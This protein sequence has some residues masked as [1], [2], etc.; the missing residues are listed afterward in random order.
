MRISTIPSYFLLLPLALGLVLPALT[1]CGGS[2]EPSGGSGYYNGP[3][4]SKSERQSQPAATNKYRSS[5][6]KSTH[7][8][9]FPYCHARMASTRISAASVSRT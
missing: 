7:G 5:P 1:G 9:A 3:M 4:K 8:P 2:N 6:D